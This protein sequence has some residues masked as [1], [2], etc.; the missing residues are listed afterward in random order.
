MGK[1]DFKFDGKKLEKSDIYRED[2]KLINMRDTDQ[3]GPYIYDIEY[4]DNDDI[5]LLIIKLS[6]MTGYCNIHKVYGKD[7]VMIKY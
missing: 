1:S 5:I 3:K 2:T 6:Q 4:D 7:V